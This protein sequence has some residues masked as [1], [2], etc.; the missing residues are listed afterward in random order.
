MAGEF[1]ARL[2][3]SGWA[4]HQVAVGAETVGAET[5]VAHRLGLD[6]EPDRLLLVV[7]QAEVRTSKGLAALLSAA[8]RPAGRRVRVLLLARVVGPWWLNLPAGCLE[9]AGCVIELPAAA[10]ERSPEEVVASAA[11]QFAGH[12]DRSLP[13]AWPSRRPERGTALL[14]L[15]AEALVAV[16]GGLRPRR[17]AA[18]RIRESWLRWCSPYCAA[19]KRWARPE[20]ARRH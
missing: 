11:E 8:D 15:H 13:Q 14:R 12:L 16:L 18:A 5:V 6:G 19:L 2:E 17:H 3:R 7:D 4:V 20:R 10:D 1:G 9:P